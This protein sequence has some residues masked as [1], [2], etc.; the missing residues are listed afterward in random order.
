MKQD[1]IRKY[2]R[3]FL[4]KRTS[5]IYKRY[6]RCA[7]SQSERVSRCSKNMQG[8]SVLSDVCRHA[9]RSKLEMGTERVQLA[10]HAVHQ[11]K[12]LPSTL[13]ISRIPSS[14]FLSAYKTKLIELTDID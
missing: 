4:L 13:F 2:G 7:Y 6:D 8:R 12:P 10:S 3:N 14:S 11:H 5:M 9:A 1:F